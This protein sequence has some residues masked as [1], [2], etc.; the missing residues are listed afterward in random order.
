MDGFFSFSLVF[1]VFS[2]LCPPYPS[3]Y[4]YNLGIVDL[5]VPASLD[6]T[7]KYTRLPRTF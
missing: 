2:D 6:C 5:F 3:Y 1:L 7:C 4:R